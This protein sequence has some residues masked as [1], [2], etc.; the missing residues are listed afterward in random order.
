MSTK[1]GMS[2][3]RLKI[4]VV[5]DS[6]PDLELIREQLSDTGYILDLT[7]VVNLNGFTT[8]LQENTF[9]IILSD[10]NLPGFDAFESL[11]ISNT[12]CPE[13][14]FICISGSIGEE[15]AIEL[16][17]LGAIDYVLKDRP[18]R[19]PFAVKRALEEAKEKSDHKRAATA[20]QQSENRFKQV[21]ENAHEWIWEID[22]D[23]LYTYASPVVQ[24]LLGYSPEEIVGKKY[25]Y[26]FFV[27]GKKEELKHS[28][29][30]VISREGSFRH[31]ENPNVHK[32]GQEV[33]MS[34]SGSPI[35]DDNGGLIGYRG[36]DTDIT[37]RNKM[38][39]ELIS[40]KEIAEESDKLKSAF[41]NIIS[42][43][44]RTPLNSILGFGRMLVESD[45]TTDQRMEYYSY[46]HKSSNRLINTV[47]DYMDM[48]RIV[49]GEM[50]VNK[51]KFLLQPQFL[52]IVQNFR[53]ACEEQNIGFEVVLPDEPDDLILDSDKE[54]IHKILHILLDNALKFT[55]QGK[56]SCGY[57]F[58]PGYIEFFVQ[59]TGIGISSN[60][61]ELI[62]DMFTQEEYSNIRGYEG[63]GL[64]LTIARGMV[65]LLKGM[66]HVTS[67]KGKGSLFT[68]TVPYEVPVQSE[69]LFMQVSPKSIGIENL[70]ILIAEDDESN[71]WYIA[72][73]LKIIGC[74]Y[75]K[76]VTGNMAVEMC[77]QN[78]KISMVLMDIK[79]PGMNGLEATQIIHGFRPDL[80]V[81]AVTA[82]AQTGD[83]SRFL[84]AGF[85]GYLSKPVTKDNL[86][87]LIQKYL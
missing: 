53:Q 8:S 46:L 20:L 29:F 79:M 17:K 58:I 60:K 84:D 51:R 50:T 15:T 65:K 64:G 61:M 21:A 18:E 87:S 39:K 7:H 47:T 69:K 2:G 19:L 73:L 77:R 66:I 13:T 10:F 4:L 86:I 37:E 44:I 80:P 38:L 75:I 31:F 16:L 72:V 11:K 74:R 33:I 67:D 14:P 12:I 27:P 24:E 78:K 45:L 52:E 34:T 48:A 36:V 54:I 81:I 1:D 70:L 62:F 82:Y 56:I 63:S 22:R 55:R 23:G 32:N 57:H 5:E 59:D 9:D 3:V 71:Y 28:T 30:G 49:S 40:A 68:F 76:A 41:I 85:N 42:H 35:F 25:F 26:D 43:E 83:E 6:I